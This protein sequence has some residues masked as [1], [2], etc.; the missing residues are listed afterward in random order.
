MEVA[1]VRV[2]ETDD[3]NLVV[4]DY[5]D[6]KHQASFVDD[7]DEAEGPDLVSIV[8][9][10]NLLRAAL[11]VWNGQEAFEATEEELYATGWM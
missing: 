2:Y 3:G 4:V 8:G 9:N 11:F 7:R 10:E 1:K 6:Q 5:L